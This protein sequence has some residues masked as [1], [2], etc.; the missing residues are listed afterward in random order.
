MRRRIGGGQTTPD[1][2]GN[3]IITKGGDKTISGKYNCM[4][5]ERVVVLPAK[6]THEI[7]EFL[8][9]MQMHNV[10]VARAELTCRE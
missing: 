8:L 7:L 5:M 10:R 1:S 9:K 6:A 3:W 2:Q 4:H